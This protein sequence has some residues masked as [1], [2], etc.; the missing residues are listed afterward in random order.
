MSHF[1]VLVVGDNPEQQLEPFNENLEVT[2]YFEPVDMEDMAEY[3]KVKPT[4]EALRNYV[5]AWTGYAPIEQGDKLGYMCTYNP[6]SKWD[7]YSLGG[8]WTGFFKVKPGAQAKVGEPGVFD[9]SA[10]PGTADQLRL[11]DIDWEAMH[12][13]AEIMAHC[14]YTEMELNTAGL[15]RPAEAWIQCR[16]R[17]DNIDEAREAF[18]KNAWVAVAGKATFAD[19]VEHYCILNGGRDTFVKKAKHSVGVPFA[20]LMDGVWYERGS[21]GWWGAVSGEQDMD[22]WCIQ[23]DQLMRDLP[24]DTLVSLYDCHI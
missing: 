24:G 3:Y 17:F 18:H 4:A 8:R 1:T 21:M 12:E 11:Q 19:P 20:V 13:E 9:N 15:E 6:S 14:M 7:W 2:P 16:E 22:E 10:D 23:V 5:F